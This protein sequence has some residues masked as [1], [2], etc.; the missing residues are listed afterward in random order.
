LRSQFDGLILG[1][2]VGLGLH[3]VG[4]YHMKANVGSKRVDGFLRTLHSDWCKP[5]GPCEGCPLRSREVEPGCGGGNWESE[6]AFVAM[7]PNETK[8]RTERGDHEV[9]DLE[10]YP[11]PPYDKFR[12]ARKGSQYWTIN[13]ESFLYERR[14]TDTLHRLNMRFEEVYY[15]NSQKCAD[16]IKHPERDRQGRTRCIGHLRCELM[17]LKPRLVVAFGRQPWDAVLEAMKASLIKR[18]A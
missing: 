3:C 1:V 4:D 11:S 17:A 10:L 2:A 18:G 16:D 12:G 15:T 6:V 13:G 7:S 8:K 5:S 14:L 9:P